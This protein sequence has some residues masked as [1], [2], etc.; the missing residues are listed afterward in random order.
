[1]PDQFPTFLDAVR[2]RHRAAL[3]ALVD[4]YQHVARNAVR[5][6]LGRQLRNRVDSDDLT[7]DF[8]LSVLRRI[9]RL[10]EFQN[11]R[12]LRAYLRRV[13]FR[14]VTKQHRRYLRAACRSIDR[15]ARVEDIEQLRDARAEG[16][17]SSAQQASDDLVKLLRSC[18]S[19]RERRIIKLKLQGLSNREIGRR[20]GVDEGSVRRCFRKLSRDVAQPDVVLE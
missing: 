9:D 18:T 6:H 4:R 10:P 12:A 3:E 2:R 17:C 8:W 5:A 14:Q 7:N 15:E 13:A 16:T 19:E 11:S 20:I 1:M